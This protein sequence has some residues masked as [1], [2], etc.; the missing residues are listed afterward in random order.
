MAVVAILLHLLIYSVGNE[1]NLINCPKS[2]TQ[3]C[4]FDNKLTA[5]KES[6]QYVNKLDSLVVARM[7]LLVPIAQTII[8]QNVIVIKSV[9]N[10]T[11]A[12]ME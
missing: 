6:L 5:R 2:T 12:V 4:T 8:C 3:N 9:T 7:I 1:T 10:I 11:I